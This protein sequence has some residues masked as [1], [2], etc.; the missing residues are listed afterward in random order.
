[1]L[2]QPPLTNQHKVNRVNW[3]VHRLLWKEEWHHYVF[4]DEKKFNF[5]GP[6]GWRYYWHD[7]RRKKSVFTKRQM[8]GGSVMVWAGFGYTGC[9]PIV[10][11]NGR[12]DSIRY[13]ALLRDEFSPHY[14]AC[15]FPP[16]IFQQDNASIHNSNRTRQWLNENFDW[17]HE[18]PAKSPDLN[19]MENMWSILSRIVYKDCKHYNSVD[20]LKEAI[21]A[22][23]AE[24]TQATRQKLVDSMPSRIV[25]V[26][27]SDGEPIDV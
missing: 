20:E 7:K 19:I 3:C 17:D 9:T 11:M 1:M 24:I 8:G 2:I 16:A 23:W 4:T 13:I 26:I 18:W 22:G 6:D 21:L 14:A 25:K 27:A 12:Y 10:F 15:A 5:D